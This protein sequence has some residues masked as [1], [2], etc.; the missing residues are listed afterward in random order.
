MGKGNKVFQQGGTK[1]A[2]ITKGPRP[3][4]PTMFHL[5]FEPLHIEVAQNSPETTAPTNTADIVQQFVSP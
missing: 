1:Q 3:S 5:M 2:G 4:S